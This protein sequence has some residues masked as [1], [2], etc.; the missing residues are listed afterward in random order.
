MKK[1]K[2]IEVITLMIGLYCRKKHK[3]PK[4]RLCTECGAL[5]DYVK[6]RR[7]KCPFGDAKTFCGNCK[8][9]CYKPQ[10]QAEIRKVMRFSGPRMVF[11]HPVMVIRHMTE[12]RRQS[13]AARAQ[14]DK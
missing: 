1:S 8:I 13:K 3:F 6:F 9:K 12:G 4:N 2:E 11:R 5:L 10:R 14:T 7:E